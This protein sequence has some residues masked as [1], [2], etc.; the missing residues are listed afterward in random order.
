MCK[1][2][3]LD[4]TQTHLQLVL[5]FDKERNGN[6][7]LSDYTHG[8]SILLFWLC[9][10]CTESYEMSIK[11]KCNGQNCSYCA[12]KK[13]GNFNNLEYKRSDLVKEWSKLNIKKPNE[14]FPSSNKKYLWDCLNCLEIYSMSVDGRTK[15]RGCPYCSGN[16]VSD[17]N[18]LEFLRPEISCEWDYETNEGLL[19]KEFT[20][21]SEF[22]VGWKCVICSY[23]WKCSIKN[24]TK[25]NGTNCPHCNSSHGEKY[26]TQYFNKNNIPYEPQKKFKELGQLSYDFY[27]PDHKI[28]I[29]FDGGQHFN[30]VNYF[31][32]KNKFKAQISNDFKKSLYAM[33]NEYHLL[34]ISHQHI[35]QIEEILDAYL[36]IICN[37]KIP[38]I[39]CHMDELN[40]S[41]LVTKVYN[42]HTSDFKEEDIPNLVNL[43]IQ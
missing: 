16:K 15:G 32:G 40:D 10:V 13:I 23:K 39:Y 19:P 42:H 25:I 9:L 3:K 8:S 36:D 26:I 41:S 18:N 7:K 33:N 43:I 27:L 1:S 37:M 12:G 31:G 34:R 24:R 11:N 35:N 14:V 38:T 17:K 30:S 21:G 2:K 28:L 6:K 5:E 29:E 4:V 22:K 20:V